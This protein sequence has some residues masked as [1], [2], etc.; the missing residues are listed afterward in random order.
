MPAELTSD[1]AADAARRRGAQVGRSAR[2][3]ATQ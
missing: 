3:L 2:Q 1:E